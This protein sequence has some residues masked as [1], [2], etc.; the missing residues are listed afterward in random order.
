[1]TEAEIL[2]TW[3]EH[4]LGKT[5]WTVEFGR[6][7]ERKVLEQSAPD[8]FMMR[9]LYENAQ[10]R[11]YEDFLKIAEGIMNRNFR[12]PYRGACPHTTANMA[13]RICREK[14]GDDYDQRR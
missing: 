2:A 6:A 7:I 4:G 12:E 13:C 14:H 5:F 8:E 9:A 1:M 10:G 3:K 11:S